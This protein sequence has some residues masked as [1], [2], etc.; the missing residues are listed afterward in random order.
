MKRRIV[1]AIFS[2]ILVWVAMVRPVAALSPCDFSPE[3][4]RLTQLNAQ[5]AFQFYDDPNKDNHDSTFTGNVEANFTWLRDS[6]LIGYRLDGTAQA[7]FDPGKSFTK[8]Q[9]TGGFK[10]F[11]SGDQFFVGATDLSGTIDLSPK[12]SAPLVAD[13]TMGMGTGRFRDV[14]PLAKAIRLQNTFLDEGVLQGPLTDD[15]LQEVAQILGLQGPTLAERIDRLEKAIEVTDLPAGGNLGA[16]ALLEMEDLISSQGEARLCGWEFQASGGLNLNNLPP[17]DIHGTLVLNWNYALVPDPVTQWTASARL[18][19]GFSLFSRYS[20]RASVSKVQRLTD[21]LRVRFTYDFSRTPAKNPN[22]STFID[23]HQFTGT[24]F[25][26][27]TN[28]L[29][30]SV[31]GELAHETGYEEMSKR[32]S[33]QLNYD[34]F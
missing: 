32:L 22:N 23:R 5:G 31:N 18:D 8:I 30:L 28:Q 26:Q 16:R 29:S 4:S 3:E 12:F 33:I 17:T 25:F 1:K 13:V 27:L 7:E 11:I 6:A 2:G 24:L 15:K 20:L 14:T 34:I 19:T 21:N 9:S 10:R